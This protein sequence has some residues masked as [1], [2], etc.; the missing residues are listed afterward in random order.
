MSKFSSL[1]TAIQTKLQADPAL[2]GVTVLV[3]DAAELSSQIDK[4]L[5]DIGM[6]VLIGQPWLENQSPLAP[7][8]NM[9]VRTSV[10]IGENPTTW[11]ADGKPVCT[12]VVQSVVEQL[13]AF[14]IP[15]FEPLRVTRADYIPN[16][17]RQLYEVAIET[18]SIFRS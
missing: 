16:K 9:K 18:M 1:T 10:A 13:Q 4:A 7:S 12:D 2:Q 11:R 15:G 6:V 17:T 8:A 3:E 14:R 5:G